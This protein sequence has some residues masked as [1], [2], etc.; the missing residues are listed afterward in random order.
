MVCRESLTCRDLLKFLLNPSDQPNKM[1]SKSC[2][3][4]PNYYIL[5]KL[6]AGR[7]IRALTLEGTV[8]PY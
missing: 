2:T 5:Q 6:Q 1:Q 3:T 4:N 7:K 8:E